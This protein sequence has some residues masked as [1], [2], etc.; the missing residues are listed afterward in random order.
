MNPSTPSA[1][2]SV[3]SP[4]SLWNASGGQYAHLRQQQQ[5]AVVATPMRA[6]LWWGADGMLTARLRRCDQGRDYEQV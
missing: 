2:M 1:H 6:A 4:I 3:A 5:H